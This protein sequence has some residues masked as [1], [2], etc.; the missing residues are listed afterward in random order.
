MKVMRHDIP[1][2]NPRLRIDALPTQ[3]RRVYVGATPKPVE[4]K[5]D[6]AP[7][8]TS[9]KAAPVAKRRTALDDALDRTAAK[10]DEAIAQVRRRWKGGKR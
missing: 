2:T 3:G 1:E 6:T 7:K 5:A 8:R 10:R 4:P 9:T